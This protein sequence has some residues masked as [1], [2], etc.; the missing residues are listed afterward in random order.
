MRVHLI[1]DSPS[2]L[3][4]SSIRYERYLDG[5]RH[6]G[7]EATLITTEAS[8]EGV[9][10]AEIVPDRAALLDSKFW[11]ARQP[12][13]VLIPTWLG[14]V[15]LLRVIR[16]HTQKIIAIADTDGFVGARAHPY[17]VF[18][19]LITQQISLKGKIRAAGWWA[20]QYLRLNRSV[21]EEMIASIRLCDRVV[22]ATAGACDNL[23][24]FL[25]S[26]NA[27]EL[28][29]R[30]IVAPYP[31]AQDF[32]QLPICTSKSKQ[33]VIIARWSDPQKGGQFLANG[34]KTFLKHMPGWR[35]VVVGSKGEFIFRNLHNAD[36][37]RLQYR[38]VLSQAEVLKLLDESRIL[39]SPSVW[40][41]GPIIAFEALLRGCSIVGRHSIPSFSEY[42]AKECGTVYRHY[43]LSDAAKALQVEADAW[44]RSKR[45]PLE[46]AYRWSD[47]FTPN[48]IC[49]KILND[50]FIKEI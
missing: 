1:F 25:K 7:H 45:F 39:F 43:R 16:P 47:M 13:F 38:N 21:D 11:A 9:D 23:H 12:E 28:R 10:W 15:D 6:L 33:V 50:S 20:R 32:N 18:E 31:V 4:D 27:Q 2:R 29:N 8:G 40:E 14:I 34:I 48:Y 35:F 37:D 30:L 46:I 19:R 26:M 44:E 3:A 36:P 17:P 41:S 22:L 42:A 49:D 5:L 24:A